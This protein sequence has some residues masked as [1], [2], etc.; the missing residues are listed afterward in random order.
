MV[1]L[2]LA[3]RIQDHAVLFAQGLLQLGLG[4]SWLGELLGVGN[5]P[6]ADATT[7]D[8]HLGLQKLL[9]LT[10]FALH[11][12]DGFAVL[13]VGIEAKNHGRYGSRRE[14]RTVPAEAA[15]SG[16]SYA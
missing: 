9:A 14:L 1:E 11:V 4:K 15:L 13:D 12:V 8:E 16:Q 10:S 3:N 7:L 2:S 5:G 6:L